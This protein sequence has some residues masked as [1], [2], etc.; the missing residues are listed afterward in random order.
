[1]GLINNDKRVYRRP[2]LAKPYINYSIAALRPGS[3]VEYA[4]LPALV[5][6]QPNGNY[7][8]YDE[9]DS[10]TNAETSIICSGQAVMSDDKKRIGV[11]KRDT[12][13]GEVAE[14]VTD[15]VFR[16]QVDYANLASTDLNGK[17]AYYD[18][19]TGL[20]I[21]A[22]PT[23]GLLV[24]TFGELLEIKPEV[25][26][27]GVWFASVTLD[28]SDQTAATAPA[29]AATANTAAITADAFISAFSADDQ[30]DGLVQVL[31]VVAAN[32]NPH[33][34]VEDRHVSWLI[35]G[36]TTLTGIEVSATFTAGSGKTVACTITT[37]DGT[38]S[39]IN[40]TVTIAASTAPASWTKV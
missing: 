18:A 24:G 34:P 28:P 14:I 7:N 11:L 3:R 35:E 27:S 6:L 2:A 21:D 16:L 38:T 25:P 36:S 13:A 8:W 31:N 37:D 10:V 23:N 4:T 20:L 19:A 39:T 26:T 17:A 30:G 1:M 9:S 33:Y 22:D 12:K 5:K 15:G 40:Y 29:D 32:N